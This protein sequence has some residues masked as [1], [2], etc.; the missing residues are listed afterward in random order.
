MKKSKICVL[1][2]GGVESS[3]LVYLLSK[4]YD[5]VFPLYASHGFIWEKAEIYWLKKFLKRLSSPSVQPLTLSRYPLKEVYPNHWSF[6]GKKVPSASSPDEAVFLPGRN[7]L[8]LSPAGIF[9]YTHQ[10]PKIAIGTLA[11]NPFP[12]S[13]RDFFSE[14]EKVLNRGLSFQIK[15]VRPFAKRGKK[16]VIRLARKAPLELS[17]S[18]LKPKEKSHCGNCNKC[19]ERKKGFARALRKSSHL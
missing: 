18:C 15:I 9:C 1:T 13:S 17:F 10:I 7:I 6:S 14:M 8:L 16:E 2:S 19:A 12:D 11:S 5:R 3:A 4:K